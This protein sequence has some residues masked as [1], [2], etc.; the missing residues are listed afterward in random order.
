MLAPVLEEVDHLVL[1]GDIWQ[2]CKLG[3]G[4]GNVRGKYEKLLGM[5]DERGISV[6][7]LRGN[8]D[9]NSGKGVAWL[10]E[11]AVL[12]NH[13]DAVYDDATPWS[14]GFPKYRQ[15]V[16]AIV[17]RYAP[18]GDSAEA[19]ADRAKEIALALKST[20]LPKLIPPFNF[21]AS[22]FWPPQRT[23][24]ILHVWRNMGDDGHRFLKQV[25]KGAR[26]LVCGH[27]HRAGI[28]E[29]DGYLVLNTGSFMRWSRAWAVDVKEGRLTVRCLKLI[30]G[31]YELGEVKGRWLLES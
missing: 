17:S 21:F 11:G 8:H 5:L 3:R 14:R 27:F 1:A 12:V 22:A 19:C 9:P 4:R 20:S 31:R 16:D 18:Q 6:E 24:E 10:A 15:D 29:K 2:E 7:V 26:V 25:G 28:W 30:D 13:G 23:F